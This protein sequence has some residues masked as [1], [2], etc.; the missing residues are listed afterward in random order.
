MKLSEISL[1]NLG[2]YATGHAQQDLLIFFPLNLAV[3]QD[4]EQS[5]CPMWEQRLMP[6]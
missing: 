2:I 3:F 6:W 1:V 5:F 4:V